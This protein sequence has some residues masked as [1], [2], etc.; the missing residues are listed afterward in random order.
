M[1]GKGMIWPS[2]MV[3]DTQVDCD[4]SWWQRDRTEQDV[5]VQLMQILSTQLR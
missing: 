1:G 3:S 5:Q 2:D 4:W